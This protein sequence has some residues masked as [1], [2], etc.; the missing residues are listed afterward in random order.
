MPRLQH[1]NLP[2]PLPPQVSELGTRASL[3]TKEAQLREEGKTLSHLRRQLTDFSQAYK[4]I[5]TERNHTHSQI[6]QLQ[7]VLP[8]TVGC[9]QCVCGC[10]SS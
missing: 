3:S 6:Q 10:V 8:L 2:L 1:P 9:C 5:K 4:L 7:Q